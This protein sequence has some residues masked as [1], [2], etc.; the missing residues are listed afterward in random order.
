MFEYEWKCYWSHVDPAG[1]AYYPRLVNAMHQAGEEYMDELG[2][3]FWNLS[4]RY[5]ID[6]PVVAMDI[7]FQKPIFVG[8]SISIGVEP[9]LGNKSLGLDFVARHADGAT[10]YTGREKHVCVTKDKESRRL[11]DELRS[12]IQES[13]E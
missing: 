12:I 10:A 9:D 6:L 2:L 4:E 3:A 11:P 8:D 7:E 1:I 13:M 5:G